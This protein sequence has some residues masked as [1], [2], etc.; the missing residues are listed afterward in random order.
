MKL[1]ELDGT[2]HDC[3]RSERLIYDAYC[4]NDGKCEMATIIYL[5]KQKGFKL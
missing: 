4:E 5:A 1:C 2:K 3:I